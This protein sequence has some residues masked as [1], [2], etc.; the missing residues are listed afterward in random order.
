MTLTRAIAA[1]L[2]LMFAAPGTVWC[3]TCPA[4][5]VAAAVDQ[6]GAAL[7][8]FTLE[9]Q[10]KL[11]ERMRR[12]RD[13]NKL[14]ETGYEDAALDAIQDSKLSELDSHSGELLL[15]IDSM[16]RAVDGDDANCAKI[17]DINAASKDLLGVMREKSAYMIA[18]LDTQIA[19]TGGG[20]ETA[21][22]VPKPEAKPEPKLESKPEPIK[23]A[24]PAAR[25]AETAPKPPVNWNANTKPNDAFVPPA[26]AEAAPKPGDVF[27]GD[28]DAGYSID[29]IRE[30]TRGFF[31]TVS[32]S[33]ASV[34]E[35]AFKTS[36]RPTAYVLGSEGGGAFLA[37]LRFGKGT[38]YL[39]N[40]PQTQEVYWHGPSIGTDFGA[41]GSRT[42]FLIY[43][44]HDSQTL[45]RSFT[46]VDGSAYFVGGVGITLLKGGEVL[47]API[48]A[49]LGFRVGANIGYVRFTDKPTWNP[50]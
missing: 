35:H 14:P 44:L 28:D 34:I 3:A 21:K 6:S 17:E 23:D 8:A 16:G 1:F 46:G 13:V 40:H 5:D 36:G 10:P 20:K 7:R 12:Y 19:E 29:E 49:G 47:M 31:G 32:T 25:A 4:S 22:V 9:T 11:S 45:F 30:A 39:R 24:K 43:S 50:F 37:G 42:M 38:L 2:F 33:L 48:R 18:K 27:V 26:V 41:S 15:K